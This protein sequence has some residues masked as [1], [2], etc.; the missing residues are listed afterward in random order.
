L[1]QSGSRT[2]SRT[3]VRTGYAQRLKRERVTWPPSPPRALLACPCP[4]RIRSQGT[5]TQILLSLLSPH[6]AL[7][8]FSL[9]TVGTIKVF[10]GDSRPATA[11]LR[12]QVPGHGGLGRAPPHSPRHWRRRPHRYP[13]P[14]HSIP[15]LERSTTRSNS[16]VAM[17]KS[18]PRDHQRANSIELPL[19]L[20]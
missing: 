13:S 8:C 1:I 3:K 20:Y 19:I 14:G 2:K 9:P 6:P 15:A 7:L 17:L 18:G 12:H 11:V 4:V 10:G 16:L 5:S